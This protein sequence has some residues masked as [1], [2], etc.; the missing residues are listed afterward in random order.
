VIG[1]DRSNVV[2]RTFISEPNRA[3]SSPSPPSLIEIEELDLLLSIFEGHKI[4]GGAVIFSP[5]PRKEWV[6]RRNS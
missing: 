5:V 2:K 1:E 6:G 3:H 4:D